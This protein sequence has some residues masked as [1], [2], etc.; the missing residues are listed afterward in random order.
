MAACLDEAQVL[1]FAAGDLTAVIRAPFEAHIDD[2]DSCR[3]VLAALVKRGVPREWAAG[4]QVGRY[5]VGPRIGR[6]G[7]GAVW[8]ADDRELGRAVA[9]KRMHASADG[10]QRARLVREARAAALLQ[11][12]NVVAVYEVGEHDGEP[13]L[14]MELVDGMTL[15]AWLREPR[16][17]R[18]IAG[19]L[20][21]AGRGLAAA[22]ASGLVHRDFKPDNVLVD[23][24]GRA[25]VADFGL[26]RAGKAH[27]DDK[28]TAA[29]AL[30]QLTETGTLSGTPAYMAPELVDGAPPDARS[31]QYAFAITAFE[32]LYGRH[33]FTGDTVEAKWIE[34]AAGRIVDVRDRRRVPK[35]LDRAVRRALA[36]DPRDRWPSVAAFVAE[37]DHKPRRTWPWLAG[38]G[39]F[40][41]AN[42]AVFAY[43]RA[44]GSD[45]ERGANLVDDVWSAA[46]RLDHARAFAAVAPGR[47]IEIATADRLVDDWADAW[48]LGRRAACRA[49]PT[50]RDTRLAC[51]D[52]ALGDL[53]AQLAAWRQPDAKVVDRALGAIAGL[54]APADCIDHAPPASHQ[55]LLEA[56]V[57]QLAALG[58]AGHDREAQ[59]QIP[60]L[61]AD[62][63]SSGD[64]GLLSRALLSAGKIE[65]SLGDG[66]HAREHDSRAV[67][68]AA[69][70]G[71]DLVILDALLDEAAVATDG[72]HPSEALGLC[73]AADALI[74]RSNLDREHRALIARADALVQLGRGPEA[75]AA[76]QRGIAILE[77]RAVR[78]RGARLQLSSAL[79]ALGGA[80]A[81][82]Q[83]PEEAR[84]AIERS[85]AIEEPELGPDHPEIGRSLHD[86]GL[87]ELELGHEV[88]GLAHVQR[89][90]TIFANAYGEH[91]PLVAMCDVALADHA[92]VT[93]ACKEAVPMYQR[94]GAGVG[95]DDPFR[96]AI[97]YGLGVCAHDLDDPRGAVDHLQHALAIYA[98][99]GRTG[100]DIADLRTEIG[101]A[102][103]ELN[104]DAEARTQA[105][106]ALKDFDAANV[107]PK[108]RVDA[109][110]VLAE[111]EHD[112]GHTPHARELLKQ[113]LATIGDDPRAQFADVRKAV[114]AELAEWT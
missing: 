111:V 68:E 74:A 65:R 97:E 108:S 58:R 103:V 71:D 10:E 23:R 29:G 110:R 45:C 30:G 7:M 89:A 20:A 36:V 32:A 76:Y 24:S 69:R 82:E 95:S 112:T 15:A 51:L 57:A 46:A 90:R 16:S 60:R 38:F 64:R 28:P 94:A 62:A 56:R 106:Q 40:V 102:L 81:E 86:L 27:A 87:Q 53:R 48:R 6:G 8:R 11:H 92:R 61:L 59:A 77:P 34:M 109:W 9:L 72:E 26:A 42:A 113:V 100:G 79:G 88:D 35:R 4:T 93:G 107:E 25:R 99:E 70:A 55:P 31:D 13:F 18:E 37:L 22:H 19:V 73:D 43:T 84:A 44:P 91:A 41:A 101:L 105:E 49:E 78:D 17:V 3:R 96:A 104:R 12:P 5:T 2:C 63:E 67:H 85:L 47:A 80:Y 66:K 75:I 14:A 83:R 114:E 21:Q 52:R 54:P 33:P 98:R 50:Q 39:V 1:A